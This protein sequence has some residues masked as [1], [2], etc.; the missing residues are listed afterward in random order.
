M[1]SR[2]ENIIRLFLRKWVVNVDI[3]TF[4]IAILTTTT[5]DAFTACHK[6]LFNYNWFQQRIVIILYSIF[7]TRL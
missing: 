2:I 4:S 3:D 5:G 7:F 1:K 6:L